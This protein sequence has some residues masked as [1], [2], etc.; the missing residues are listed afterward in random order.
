MVGTF[1]PADV[2]MKNVKVAD[3]SKDKEAL[4]FQA[5]MSWDQHTKSGR[6]S[7][8]YR[9]TQEFHD[10]NAA[11]KHERVAAIEPH[12]GKI[13]EG[14]SAK[15]SDA[16]LPQKQ[17]EAAAIANVI[18]ETGLRPTDG[19][20]SVKHGHFGISSLQAHHVK[21]EGDE[22][23]LDF[24]GKEGIRNQTVVRDPANVAFLKAATEG[25]DA[26]QPVFE[27][28]DSTAAGDALK[29]LSVASGG[30][31][32][33]KVKDL[34]TLKAHQIARAAVEH[35]PGP[36]P[37]LSGDKKKD[38]KL[39]Q[40]AILKMSGEVSSVLNNQPTEARDTY[41][42]PEIFKGWQAKLALAATTE[43]GAA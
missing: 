10:R 36:P 21:I 5:L 4:K 41:I 12:I 7:R 22:A 2:D 19:D 33:I 11:E 28:A 27:K 8:Q 29:E 38:V 9:Y 32:D 16:A 26:A 24:I 25:K 15:M 34:R 20:E 3:L 31:A 37:P 14:L 17:R 13:Q 6:V 40:A 43:Q 18:R 35:F 1:P 23:R 39:V 30:P 42:H